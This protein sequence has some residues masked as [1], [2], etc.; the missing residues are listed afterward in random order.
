MKKGI[1]CSVLMASLLGTT[2]VMTPLMTMPIYA[3]ESRITPT[4]Q[5]S[6]S[7]VTAINNG[8]GAINASGD[9]S[10]YANL[11]D[12]TINGTFSLGSNSDGGV[13]SIF[14]IGD[15]TTASN[16]FTLYAIPS[17]KKL[18]VELRNVSG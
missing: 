12:F 16:Y 1:A 15:N 7:M 4:N 6:T 10:N 3:Q 5:Y 2:T 8:T 14:F 9:V 13:N 17:A 18:G 11:N